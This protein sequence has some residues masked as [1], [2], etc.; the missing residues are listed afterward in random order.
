MYRDRL[1]DYKTAGEYKALETDKVIVYLCTNK[2]GYF[3]GQSRI[4]YKQQQ[5][6]KGAGGESQLS[7]A[8]E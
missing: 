4:V 8:Y 5:K 6:E 3:N 7:E 2:D 1:E